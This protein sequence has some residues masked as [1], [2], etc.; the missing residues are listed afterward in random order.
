MLHNAR[1]HSANVAPK[2]QAT[3]SV[4]EAYCCDPS[5]DSDEGFHAS[6]ASLKQ[7]AQ[8][9]ALTPGMRD[10]ASRCAEALEDFW[11]NKQ[12]FGADSYLYRSP[13][14]GNSIEISGLQVTVYP[15]LQT[16]D[17]PPE[18]GKKTGLIFIR[19]QKTPNPEDYKSA[20]T[21][22]AKVAY[23]EEVA[24]FLLVI[25]RMLAEEAGL[26]SAQFDTKRSQVWDIRLG[27]AIGFPTDWVSRQKQVFAA[28]KQIKN[29]WDSIEPKP[30]DLL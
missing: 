9:S 3:R 6:V 19:P 24:K 16:G 13:A 2:N 29:L 30:G 21:R 4:I 10:E 1:F 14:F 7:K 26:Q 5:H 18:D 11:G 25:G 20:E 15:N 28:A 8:D 22:A 12:A 23:R 17:F 27:R